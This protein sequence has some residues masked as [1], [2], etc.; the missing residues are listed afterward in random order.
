[1]PTNYFEHLSTVTSNL[2]DGG[3]SL[4]AV[5]DRP[6]ILIIGPAH[7]GLS[8]SP[9]LIVE[10]SDVKRLYGEDTEMERRA[11][12]ILAQAG[13]QA[14]YIYCMRIG[15][16][17]PVIK[18]EAASGGTIE[19]TPSTYHDNQASERLQLILR[20]Y[21]AIPGSGVYEQR[22]L[23]RDSVDE[24]LI[25][26][27]HGIEDIIYRPFTISRSGDFLDSQ[28]DVYEHG[29]SDAQS[30]IVPDMVPIYEE[31]TSGYV[32]TTAD[33][34]TLTTAQGNQESIN[35][36]F[37]RAGNDGT[38][39]PL[40]QKYVFMDKSL[41]GLNFKEFDY[42]LP[43]GGYFIDA[44]NI[45]DA[46]V[47]N[48]AGDKRVV[49]HEHPQASLYHIPGSATAGLSPAGLYGYVDWSLALSDIKSTAQCITADEPR[50]V[51]LVST[52]SSGT[53]AAASNVL[54]WLWQTEY[55]QKKYYYFASGKGWERFNALEETITFSVDAQ[56]FDL[57]ITDVSAGVHTFNLSLNNDL[58]AGN[59]TSLAIALDNSALIGASTWAG[60]A[61]PTLTIGTLNATI[62]DV[63][64]FLENQLSALV[65]DSIGTNLPNAITIT[66]SVV[67]ANLLEDAALATI[68]GVDF[69]G[70]VT[71]IE[72][73]TLEVGLTFDRTY[74]PY[75]ITIEP[76]NGG[77]TVTISENASTNGAELTI[78]FDDSITLT[79]L[80][81]ALTGSI[82]NGTGAFTFDTP[83]VTGGADA[84]LNVAASAVSLSGANDVVT[85]ASPLT[86]VQTDL[87]LYSN[88][89]YD[90][91]ELTGEEIPSAVET[92]FEA[93]EAGEFR[94]CSFA[95]QLATFCHKSSSTW[96]TISTC[97]SFEEPM[98]Q[99]GSI[100]VGDAPIYTS[101]SG[102]LAIDNAYEGGTGLLGY[103]FVAGAPG[104]RDQILGSI[105]S[106][107]DG[108]AYGGLVM[109]SG[110]LLPDRVTEPYG[111]EDSDEDKD[112]RGFAIDIGK[113]IVPCAMWVKH[114][115]TY[116]NS[117]SPYTGPITGVVTGKLGI[118]PISNEPI[119]VVN[120]SL[121][122][123]RGVGLNAS[124]YPYS[125]INKLAGN[126]YATVV[127][128]PGRGTYINNLRTM[129]HRKSDYRKVSTVRAVNRVVQ[130]VRNLAEDYIGLA[131]NSANVASLQ[132]SINGY[133]RAEQSAGIHNGAIAQIAFNRADRLL[134]NIKIRI[135]MVPPFAIE[136][137]TVTTSLIADESNLTS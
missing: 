46:Y 84:E 19:L 130:G 43:C 103:K 135:T 55:E 125:T 118:T 44:P 124:G 132:T 80:E 104:Y 67:S 109:T 107:S 4:A 57:E 33:S 93:A 119:G 54:G 112:A 74:D 31:G 24:A 49:H 59:V 102:K 105:A 91:Y 5:G 47:L 129:A 122:G 58:F 121:S 10:A 69:P 77:G 20:S 7:S 41:D 94:E 52:Q 106:S 82:T 127:Y 76:S 38:N 26:D 88:N 22:I 98:L 133:L 86:G 8:E 71:L 128:R 6:S 134:G 79:Q 17:A 63:Q 18:L 2:L 28:G 9:Q 21:E 3:L 85:A 97:M 40:V 110:D 92:L 137:I 75:S 66:S 53:D 111:I 100:K 35:I 34:N 136:S 81:S 48:S 115:N 113:Y 73:G 116:D 123:V 61:T 42:I 68:T 78:S 23:I 101:I 65:A 72:T 62:A 25:W 30:Y 45:A 29:F 83:V 37:T 56:S 12:E 87:M 14:Y 95:H 117:G 16:I 39:V 126:G 108:Y 131:Y 1:M 51:D 13:D 70:P 50:R 99:N 60:G 89:Y 64:A 96:K 36:T 90:H 15:G 32:Y 11:A 27:S 120:G 114:S